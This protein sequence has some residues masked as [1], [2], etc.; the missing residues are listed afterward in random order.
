MNVTVHPRGR[1]GLATSPRQMDP[2]SAG[3]CCSSR[4]MGPSSLRK[5][6]CSIYVNLPKFLG[7]TKL[8][9]TNRP[10]T[11][12]LE[13]LGLS[14]LRKHVGST[15]HVFLE[16]FRKTMFLQGTQVHL[17]WGA[18]FWAHLLSQAIKF[19]QGI[20]VQNIFRNH[21]SLLE[22]GL[23]LP[24]GVLFPKELGPICFGD[25]ASLYV[26]REACLRKL[27]QDYI[28]FFIHPFKKNE[29]L[30]TRFEPWNF[31]G[32]I[33]MSTYNFFFKMM[34]Q[35]RQLKHLSQFN[36]STIQKNRKY[37]YSWALS[38]NYVESNV[39][40]NLFLLFNACLFNVQK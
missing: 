29:N 39:T 25:V 30:R 36:S 35:I 38:C 27:L 18:M 3:K 7:E 4:Q 10:K 16:S 32:M 28:L 26:A 14:C 19:T 34:V 6:D 11:W 40:F 9:K 1:R 2:S 13:Q 24:Q 8:L 12:C 37:F 22:F 17:P 5:G 15:K 21:V 23:I 33:L 20:W 31:E